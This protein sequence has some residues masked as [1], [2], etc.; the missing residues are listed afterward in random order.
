[1]GIAEQLT[2]DDPAPATDDPAELLQRGVLVRH[3]AE[4]RYDPVPGPISR[5]R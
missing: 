1:M 2:D 4:H 5:M 3:L